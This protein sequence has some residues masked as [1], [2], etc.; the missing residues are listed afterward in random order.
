MRKGGRGYKWVEMKGGLRDLTI[1][2][3][4]RRV[5]GD[6]GRPLALQP[7]IAVALTPSPLSSAV[8]YIQPSLGDSYLPC[9]SICLCLCLFV[10]VCRYKQ[11]CLF[12]TISLFQCMSLTLRFVSVCYF[13]SNPSYTSLCFC[14]S[15]F[16]SLFLSLCLAL[17]LSAQNV[18]SLLSF[19]LLP[20]TFRPI[21]Y[22]PVSRSLFLSLHIFRLL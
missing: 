10:S 22:L 11:N 16:R 13:L 6:D 8:I 2:T 4:K 15:V 17:S 21:D 3:Y 7:S 18:C 14:L 12:L 5:T 9:L 19:P 20:S 1:L